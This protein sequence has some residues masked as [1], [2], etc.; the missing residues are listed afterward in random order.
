M[1]KQRFI[2][3]IKLNVLKNLEFLSKYTYKIFSYDKNKGALLKLDYI[4][5]LASLES[6]LGHIQG[7]GTDN[8]E[9]IYK[10]KL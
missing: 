1:W 2:R 6:Y 5:M 9:E 8:Y 4:F 10:L 3:I 7:L